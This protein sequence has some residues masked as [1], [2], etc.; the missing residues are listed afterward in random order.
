MKMEI[1]KIFFNKFHFQSRAEYCLDCKSPAYSNSHNVECRKCCRLCYRFGPNYP[2]KQPDGQPVL[3]CI[4]CQ[5]YFPNLSC[6]EWHKKRGNRGGL[7]I[8]ET[9]FYCKKCNKVVSF[10]APKYFIN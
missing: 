3:P 8:C 6:F 9:R 1:P 4:D 10:L 2:C 5:F 7:S